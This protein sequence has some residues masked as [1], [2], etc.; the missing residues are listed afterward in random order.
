MQKVLLEDWTGTFVARFENS[1]VHQ[2]ANI[3]E[4]AHMFLQDVSVE[5]LASMTRISVCL[6]EQSSNNLNVMLSMCHLQ[7]ASRRLVMHF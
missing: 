6:S 1:P 7:V 2:I 5:C 3:N 4:T